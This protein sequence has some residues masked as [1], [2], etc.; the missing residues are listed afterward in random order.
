MP[1]RVLVNQPLRRDTADGGAYRIRGIVILTEEGTPG[2][3]R[4]RL[5]ERYSARCVRETWSAADGTYAFNFIAYREQGYFVIASDDGPDPY[6]AAIAD[7]V[8]PEPM[9]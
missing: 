8:T 3:Y 1:A 2:R 6:N 9:L 4:V 5:F 7:Y